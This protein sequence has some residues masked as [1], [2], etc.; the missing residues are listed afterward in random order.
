[1][2]DKYLGYRDQKH[3]ISVFIQGTSKVSMKNKVT[4]VLNKMSVESNRELDHR[5][6]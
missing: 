3:L 2:S 1:M 6:K 4:V 5:Q